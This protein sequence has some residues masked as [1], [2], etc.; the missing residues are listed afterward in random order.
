MDPKGLATLEDFYHNKPWWYY[1][2]LIPKSGESVD[3]IKV[4]YLSVCDRYS[5][6]RIVIST[7]AIKKA[8]YYF[9]GALSLLPIFLGAKI[10]ATFSIP[11]HSQYQ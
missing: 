4:G 6:K 7:V 10:H 8:S 3:A 1:R 5:Q 9:P 2:N 11:K